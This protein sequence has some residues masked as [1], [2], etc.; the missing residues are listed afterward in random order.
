M[1]NNIFVD[2][3]K[4]NPNFYDGYW[5][6]NPRRNAKCNPILYKDNYRGYFKSNLNYR[7]SNQN[8]C[9]VEGF[10]N[11]PPNNNVQLVKKREQSKHTN[12]NQQI[13]MKN[14]DDLNTYGVINDISCNGKIAQVKF[15]KGE[16]KMY[17][18]DLPSIM[19]KEVLGDIEE[20]DHIHNKK[21]KHGMQYGDMKL[22]HLQNTMQKLHYQMNPSL[23]HAHERDFR[24]EKFFQD[25]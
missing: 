17:D 24:R 11:L 5:R 16:P 21:I 15:Q 12:N 19:K 23:L 8:P 9:V 4:K 2:Y 14:S 18:I 22:K 3:S 13:V 25:N 6:Q 20:I 7:L 10:A 1:S